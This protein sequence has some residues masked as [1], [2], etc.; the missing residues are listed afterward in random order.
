MKIKNKYISFPI[1]S[2][3]Q[4]NLEMQAVQRELNKLG[5]K[6]PSLTTFKNK[7]FLSEYSS[8]SEDKQNTFIKLIGGNANYKKTKGFLE[9]LKIG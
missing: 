1:D 3:I 5:I 4:V 2:I 9:S 7:N 8:W 6:N